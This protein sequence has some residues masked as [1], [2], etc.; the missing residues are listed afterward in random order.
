MIEKAFFRYDEDVCPSQ[1]YISIS[2][3]RTSGNCP[4]VVLSNLIHIDNDMPL[5]E[6]ESNPIMV[7][8]GFES[9]VVVVVV[10]ILYN[11][12]SVI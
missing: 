9:V 7:I 10:V 6:V 8:I 4:V 11:A 3:H 2:A 5:I 1:L 12:F